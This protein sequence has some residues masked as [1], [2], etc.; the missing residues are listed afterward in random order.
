MEGLGNDFV[1]LEGVDP[2][3]DL[4]RR[5][6]DRRRG[7]GADGVLVVDSAPGMRYWNADGSEAEMCGNGLRCVAVYS[8]AREWTAPGEWFDVQTAIGPR[9]ARVDRDEVTVEVGKV[10]IAGTLSVHGRLYHEASVGN[11]H[12][13]T[14]VDDPAAVAVEEEGPIVENDP[15][16]P[17]GTNVEFVALAGPDRLRLRVWERGVGETL[18]C[19]S[20]MVVAAAVATGV[21]EEPVEVVVRGGV[22]RVSF[23]GGSGYLTGPVVTV[24]RGEWAL[25][26]D[27]AAR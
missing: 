4:V 17:H 11:P 20:G 26:A 12:A 23:H 19:G 9:R 13:V 2:S 1:M 22:G 21:R 3:P 15:A 7:I 25:S 27:G 16:F 24:F 14:V 5:L 6:C 10:S 18:A 8:V